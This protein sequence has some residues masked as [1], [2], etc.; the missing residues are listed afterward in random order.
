[1]SFGT[2]ICLTIRLSFIIYLSIY[3]NHSLYD[4]K[5]CVDRFV[6][7]GHNYQTVREAMLKSIF[8]NDQLPLKNAL[9]VSFIFI[10]SSY[11]CTYITWSKNIYTL[12][13][14]FCADLFLQLF[15][16]LCCFWQIIWYKEN[17]YLQNVVLDNFF[18]IR[19]TYI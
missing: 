2:N 6:V 12:N 15:L 19:K 14:K 3:L 16:C 1:M 8:G 18:Y 11:V 13:I 17:K 9:E 7:C 4:F 5:W 10:I